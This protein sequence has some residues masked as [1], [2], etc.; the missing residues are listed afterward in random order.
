MTDKFEIP[1]TMRDFA[2]K[3]MDHARKAFED[4]AASAQK[5][6]GTLE[7][8]T[9]DAQK[10]AR[11]FGEMA[12][13]FAEENMAASFDYAKNMVNAKSIEDLMKIQSDFI[14]R[15]VANFSRQSEDLATGAHP[16]T[17]DKD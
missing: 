6:V 9:A 16:R 4:Y 2:E 11:D 12:I 3:S 7:N 5:A 17:G 1:E 8:S 10:N 13:A 14:E 15:Q